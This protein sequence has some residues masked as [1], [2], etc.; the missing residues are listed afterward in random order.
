MYRLAA[1]QLSRWENWRIFKW[2]N[3][4]RMD[5]VE[6]TSEFAQLMFDGIVGRS[7]L[8]MDRLYGEKD[9]R[10]PER[11]EIEK[12]FQNTMDVLDDNL[13]QVLPIS[14]FRKRAPFYALFAAVYDVTYGI[15]S[16]LTRSKPRRP[17]R[18]LAQRVNQLSDA[19]T[20]SRAPRTVLEALE[21]RTTH[22][23]SRRTV[24]NYLTEAL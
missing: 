13:G 3:I 5:E 23:G 4:A 10:F 22:P 2:D 1:E 14:A 18:D 11:K 16:A 20:T 6:L 19:I 17:H 8:S 7:Q 24:V 15:G 9:Q 21:R 12:R